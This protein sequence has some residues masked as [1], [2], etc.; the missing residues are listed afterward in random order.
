M[1]LRSGSPCTSTSSPM[2]SCS[3]ITRS[4]LLAHEVV[5]LPVVDLALAQARARG[6][7]LAGLREGAD[8]RGR[9]QRQAEA[10][11]LRVA[12]RRRTGS[13]GVAVG[14]GH[15]R[16]PLAHLRVARARRVAPVLERLARSRR[17]PTAIASRP[18]LVARV[19][20]ATSSSFCTAN[21]IQLSTSASRRGS[22]V[23]STGECCSELRGGRPRPCRR[24]CL[25]SSSI[26]SRLAARSLIQ[27]LR[28][29]T[30]PAK[31][32]LSSG[33]PCLR[34]EVAVLRAVD[35]VERHA[36]DGQARQHRVGVADV[37]EVGRDDDL[38]SAFDARPASCRRARA[39]RAPP[40]CGPRPAPAR[41]TA[42]TPRRA[43][44]QLGEHLRVDGDEVV[45]QLE[46]VELLAGR[47]ALQ[48]EGQRPDEHRLRLDAQRLRLG[49][50]LQRLARA[51]AELH[52]AARARERCSGSS[53]RTTSSSPSPSRRRRR[54]DGRAPWRSRCRGRCRSIRP[55]R[56][57]P[58]RRPP[59]RW[60]RAPGRRAR[61]RWTG[62]G[63]SPRR[64][65]ASSSRR[66]APW[67][68]PA[69]PPSSGLPTSRTRSRT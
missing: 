39:P 21:D 37:V 16:E 7:D 13:R 54:S 67:R 24:R 55:T 48:Q 45:E 52:P 50:V 15:L 53:C 51:E 5:V 29:L 41:R 36:G 64:A 38:R 44:P 32:I 65:G 9:E 23:L 14:V 63:R 58:G 4:T 59:S 69:G 12:A 33:Q 19:S 46:V 1:S 20:A 42:P 27:T 68:S 6:A 8:R 11:V 43:S 18:S 10:L 2:S 49:V 25:R 56:S 47:L 17:A 30:T 62:S 22:L 57:G 35:E 3:R 28:P 34:D 31:R 60:C 61:S 66:A 40:A 26:R